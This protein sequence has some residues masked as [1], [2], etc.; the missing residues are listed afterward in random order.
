MP[1]EFFETRQ[2]FLSLCQG[3]H[4]QF[5]SLRRAKHSSMMVRGSSTSER[6]GGR[7]CHVWFPLTPYPTLR[8]SHA[9]RGIYRM[10]P[11]LRNNL[12]NDTSVTPL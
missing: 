2:A 7:V 8:T 1:S 3:N 11:V 4:Y 10:A 6:Q 5:D 12:T 9:P